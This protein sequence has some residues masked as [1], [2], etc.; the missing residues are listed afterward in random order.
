M[1][2]PFACS[3]QKASG[4]NGINYP[5]TATAHRIAQNAQKRRVA[6]P[7]TVHKFLAP[8]LAH[9]HRFVL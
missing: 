9:G 3:G 1:Y 4:G 6:R 7:R 2:R 8:P 5:M